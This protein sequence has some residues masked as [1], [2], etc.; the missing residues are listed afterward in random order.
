[1]KAFRFI[2][3]ISA[4]ALLAIFILAPPNNANASGVYQL[5]AVQAYDLNTD[6]PIDGD[7]LTD[8]RSY[9]IADVGGGSQ[10]GDGG[11]TIM[12][13]EYEFINS[14]PVQWASK[15]GGSFGNGTKSTL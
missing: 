12:K 10:S 6:K 5:D 7:I 8:Y 13:S 15:G 11:S 4:L 14:V 9:G 1:M 3:C 2:S